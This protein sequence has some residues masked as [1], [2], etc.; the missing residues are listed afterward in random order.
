M[1]RLQ[2]SCVIEEHSRVPRYLQ[3][4][5]AGGVIMTYKTCRHVA[6]IPCYSTM[7]HSWQKLQPDRTGLH[8]RPHAASQGQQDRVHRAPPASSL[9]CN[10]GPGTL[11]RHAEEFNDV[12]YV[13][14][15]QL[16]QHLLVPHTLLECNNNRSIRDVRDGVANLGELLDEGAQ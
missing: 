7:L 12:L 14:H 2:G 9:H 15:G 10:C 4:T 6:T 16:L 11:V 1:V 5:Q 3:V 13:V 8:D